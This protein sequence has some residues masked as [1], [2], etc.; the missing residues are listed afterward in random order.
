MKQIKQLAYAIVL[1]L[2]SA[3]SYA[4]IGIGTDNPDPSAIL[5]L[6]ATDK[7]FK[8]PEVELTGR[9]DNSTIP[10]PAKGLIV[11]NTEDNGSS[12]NEV[13]ANRYYFWNGEEWVSLPG[14]S[15]VESLIKQK[16][17]IAQGTDSQ[18]FGSSGYDTS[19]I[20]VTFSG[21]SVNTENIITFN[22]A[23]DTFQVNI[24][25]T[26]EISSFINYDPNNP[27]GNYRARQHLYIQKR[28]SGGSWI[29]IAGV[30]ATWGRGSASK[31]RT[32]VLPI[33]LVKLNQGDFI[34][35]VTERYINSDNEEQGN[36]QIG[37]FTNSPISKN[38][39]LKL[40]DYNF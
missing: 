29:D 9:I 37:S 10:N 33:T 3:Q 13:Y 16:I 27:S 18:S 39:T 30:R 12:P 35:V 31:F 19:E 8:G 4:Q 2:V 26:Y 17:F 38:L 11:Y 24:K 1:L 20:V 7:G 14:L 28:T 22:N 25:G 40:V 5:E 34:R 36:G 23:D 32:I 15:N 21:Y 6:Q